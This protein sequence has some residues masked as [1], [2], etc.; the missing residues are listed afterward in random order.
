MKA[1]DYNT[2]EIYY[3]VAISIQVVYIT[4]ILHVVNVYNVTSETSPKPP[5]NILR[6]YFMRTNVC[7]II[8]IHYIK[9][10]RGTVMNQHLPE[11]TMYYAAG[12][13]DEGIIN[14]EYIYESIEAA[15]ASG[16]DYTT[17]TWAIL[18]DAVGRGQVYPERIIFTPQGRF[19]WEV[20]FNCKEE[21]EFNI[22]YKCVYR[23]VGAPVSFSEAVEYHMFWNK[24]S[25]LVRIRVEAGMYKAVIKNWNGDVV[26]IKS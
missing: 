8:A 19:I 17:A 13:S 18:K 11:V 6:F 16:L 1:S 7:V 21:E 5:Q 9:A 22:P 4:N 2:V 3:T 14:G 24:G 15:N 26:V 12:I 20:F 10:K 23:A 25:E